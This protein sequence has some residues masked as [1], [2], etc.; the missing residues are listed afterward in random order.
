MIWSIIESKNTGIIA[1][2]KASS[3]AS[4]AIIVFAKRDPWHVVSAYWYVPTGLDLRHTSDLDRMTHSSTRFRGSGFIEAE[5]IYIATVPKIRPESK[6]KA[7]SACHS[8]FAD[9]N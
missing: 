9:L 7:F 6:Y 1:R 5:V 3:S 2:A 8:S 4:V